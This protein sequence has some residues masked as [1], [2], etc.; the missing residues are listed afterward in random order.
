MEE[1]NHELSKFREASANIIFETT[2]ND[3]SEHKIKLQHHKNSSLAS[4]LS[5]CTSLTKNIKP[6]QIFSNKL[7]E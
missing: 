7:N 1:Q 3:H 5:N 6:L 2:N 4:T